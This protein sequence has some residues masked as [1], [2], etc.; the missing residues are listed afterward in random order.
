MKRALALLL[1]VSCADPVAPAPGSTCTSIEPAIAGAANMRPELLY[2]VRDPAGDDVLS[3]ALAGG[4]DEGLSLA[5]GAAGEGE[6]LLGPA[7]AP[8]LK[9]RVRDADAARAQAV[10]GPIGGAGATPNDLVIA[11]PTD[12]PYAVIARSGDNA[13]SAYDL[14]TGLDAGLPGVRLPELEDQCGRRSA[15]P[16][17]VAPLGGDRVAVTAFAQARVHVLDMRAGAIEATL[18]VPG[19]MALDPPQE[20]ARAIDADCDGT[21]ESMISRFRPRTPQ[22]V[23]LAGDSLVAGF[24]NFYSASPAVYLPGVL[25]IWTVT[26]LSASPRLLQLPAFNPQEL[27]ALD[28]RRVLVVCSGVLEQVGANIG[29]STP[30]MVLIVD[31]E[32][33]TIERT[34]EFGDFA[35]GTALLAGGSVWAGS[36]VKPALRAY[37]LESGA[38]LHELLLN[39]EPV[40]SV[41]RLIEL[42]GGL[43]GAPSFNTDRLHIFDPRAGILD[44]APFFGPLQ[45]GPGRP[46]FDGLAILAR[47]PGR[48]G[49]DFVGPDLFALSGVASKVT[50]IE[51]RKVLGP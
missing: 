46:I 16:W 24:T 31:L 11:G 39:D 42:P 48:A 49:I 47:R 45:I 41:F 28:D 51:L 21:R 35:P 9:Y 32:S 6:V 22:A 27:R 26:D 1:L 25:A 38:Q 10:C 23:A 33:A 37:D 29:A 13:V 19:T 7:G 15:N 3:G 8:G 4:L 17:F 36:L 34:F 5:E 43:V 14:A 18:A 44:P 12:A 20:V 2:A 30:G 40:D 50:P